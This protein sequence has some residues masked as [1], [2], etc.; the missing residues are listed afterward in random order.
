MFLKVIKTHT[1]AETISYKNYSVSI[2]LNERAIYLKIIDTINFLSYEG[3]IDLKELRVPVDLDA[4]YK[5]MVNGFKEQNDYSVCINANSGNIKII[6]NAIFSGFLKINFEVLLREKLMSNDG[7]LTLNFNKLEQQQSHAIKSLTEKCNNLEGVLAKQQKDFAE[8]IEFL[9]G[10]INGIDIFTSPS[11]HW[12]AVHQTQF[13]ANIASTEL[14]LNGDENFNAKSIS[15]FYQLEKLTI[16]GFTSQTNL[17]NVNNI[18]LK[19]L[20]LNCVGNRTFVSLDGIS[21]FPNLE[22]LT[23]TNASGLTN[24]VTILKNIKHKIKTLKFQA[25]AA[26]NVVEL[27]T[28]CQVNNVFLA[29]S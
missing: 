12:S 26:V 21:N 4:A 2:S 15:S 13:T 3:N 29:L 24:V 23:I 1:M 22:I 5:V 28:Y 10:V 20:I 18:K 17:K 6:F 25:C 9:K 14:A 27:Q 19:E 7:Q 16:N 8:Q 11:H